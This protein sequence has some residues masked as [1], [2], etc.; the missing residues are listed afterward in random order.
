MEATRAPDLLILVEVGEDCIVRRV[1]VRVAPQQDQPVSCKTDQKGSELIELCMMNHA[2]LN[3]A[4]KTCTSAP[5]PLWPSMNCGEAVLL[6]APKAKAPI[7]TPT[8][9]RYANHTLRSIPA[10]LAHH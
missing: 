8:D 5:L 3:E 6:D 10:P 2:P 9:Y 4:Q 1:R 7:P